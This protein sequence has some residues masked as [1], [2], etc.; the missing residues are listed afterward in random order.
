MEITRLNTSEFLY[1]LDELCG[2]E[3]VFAFSFVSSNSTDVETKEQFYILLH[4]RY[5][6]D[7]SG[8][9]N[10]SRKLCKLEENIYIALCFLLRFSCVLSTMNAF[11]GK[12]FHLETVCIFQRLIIG[13]FIRLFACWLLRKLWASSFASSVKFLY[14]INSSVL[15]GFLPL[16]NPYIF[17]C[18]ITMI[19]HVEISIISLILTLSP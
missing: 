8:L 19:S 3:L 15:L 6:C 16:R 17:T 14:F 13:R 2:N 10:F 4:T 1:C 18:K 11:E 9:T 5:A 7:F 12:K